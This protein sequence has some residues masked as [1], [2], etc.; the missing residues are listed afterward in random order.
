[1]R[2]E[3]AERAEIERAI[4]E[5]KEAIERAEQEAREAEAAAEAE[6]K[7]VEE[8][9]RL[10]E[11]EAK[12]NAERERRGETTKSFPVT[13][14]VTLNHRA[15][16]GDVEVEVRASAGISS[17]GVETAAF[18]TSE[19]ARVGALNMC[20]A[21]ARAAMVNYMSDVR[22]KQMM[23][24]P[25]VI[26]VETGGFDDVEF[27]HWMRVAQAGH[28]H[29]HV[30]F[31]HTCVHF[32][33]LMLIKLVCFNLPSRHRHHHPCLCVNHAYVTYI[34]TQMHSQEPYN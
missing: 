33:S 34:T 16:R 12:R 5:E 26:G 24:E 30:L 21:V 1:M 7:R 22:L 3:L 13:A 28:V 27:D 20:S 14:R 19:A 10:A 8:A 32:S 29:F 9:E 15:A 11:E 2:A 4:I 17:P 31:T 25:C 6:R 23:G 18:P